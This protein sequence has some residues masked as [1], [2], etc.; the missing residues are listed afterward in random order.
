M[1]VSNQSIPAIAKIITGDNQISPYRSGS[2]LVSFFK[3]FGFKDE[4][5]ENFPSRWK[6]VEDKITEI[7]GTDL[8]NNV[9]ISV[10]DPRYFY[11]TEFSEDI[12]ADFLN[13]YLKFDGYKLTRKGED[14]F[15][16]MTLQE[17]SRVRMENQH[18]MNNEFVKEQLKK[19]KSKLDEGDY[20]GAITNSRTLVEGIIGEI[21][22]R[23]TGES[24]QK[25]GDL[26]KD[27]KLITSFLKLSEEKYSDD[28]IKQILRGVISILV[29]IDSLS[30]QMGDR[31]RRPTKPARHHAKLCVNSAILTSDFLYDI[32]DYQKSKKENVYEGIISELN[33]PKRLWKREKIITDK[34]IRKYTERMDTYLKRLFINKLINNFTINSFKESDTFFAALDIVYQELSEKDIKKIFVQLKENNQ[35]CGLPNFLKTLK[36]ERPQ[37]VNNKTIN[38]FIKEFDA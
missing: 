9:T 34:E 20:D 19:C 16:V 35:A 22:E 31:H 12:A 5:V 29:G 11:D 17:D 25:S 15:L 32:L 21:H 6:Y 4:Y 10:L 37:I 14:Q 24:L 2:E 18:K 1:L 7:N 26:F 28:R 36:K 33:G 38:E 30:N 23:A 13:K 27:Y 3:L 8:L